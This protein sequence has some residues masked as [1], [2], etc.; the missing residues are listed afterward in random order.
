M[1]S[2]LNFLIFIFFT[3]VNGDN[4]LLL[5]KLPDSS[6]EK[7]IS[8]QQVWHCHAFAALLM[9]SISFLLLKKTDLK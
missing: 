6:L 1:L 9:A 2:L 5:A 3:L 4:K 8:T 7:T